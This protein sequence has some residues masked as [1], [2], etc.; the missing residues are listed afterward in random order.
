[1]NALLRLACFVFLLCPCM[2]YSAE[3]PP[4]AV[5]RL[6]I[7]GIDSGSQSISQFLANGFPVDVDYAQ[8]PEAP[9]EKCQLLI[10]AMQIAGVQRYAEVF[11]SL[12][13]LARKTVS[14]GIEGMIQ[15]DLLLATPAERSKRREQILQF[16]QYNAAVALSIIGDTRALPVM[17]TLF[18]AEEDPTVKSQYALGMA[19]LGNGSGIEHLLSEIDK[20]NQQSSV[21]SAQSLYYITG[22]DYGLRATSPVKLREKL[23][24]DYRSWWSEN[25][26]ALE[27]DP[28][29]IIRRRLAPL[30][31][32]RLSMDKVRDLV[33]LSTNYTDFDDRLGSRTAEKR[34]E[35]LGD[36]AA[37]ELKHI[38]SDPMEDLVVRSAALRRYVVLKKGDS[39]NALKKLQ[40]DENPEIAAMAKEQM[41][42]VESGEINGYTS[43]THQQIDPAA[44]DENKE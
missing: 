19:C 43:K 7:H 9:A 36:S 37:D 30:V 31:A 41:A 22:I 23:A 13:A 42:L 8:M 11:D 39:K 28:Q 3:L 26:E 35:D 12:E 20:A 29:A 5:E 1:M 4:R 27:I 2:S 10:D 38:A 33:A 24:A 25:G 14:P 34:L 32:P 40:K 21:A 18:R 6:R 16:L 17:Q 44:A 15:H